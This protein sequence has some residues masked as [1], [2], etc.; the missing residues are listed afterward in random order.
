M[1]VVSHSQRRK[2]CP[3]GCRSS[4]RAPAT[5]AG[6]I[7]TAAMVMCVSSSVATM[8][9]H[10]TG[11]GHAIKE[12][13]KIHSAS[14]G[15]A[16]N[17]RGD[18][19]MASIVRGTPERRSIGP[20]PQEAFPARCPAADSGSA[21][22]QRRKNRR[23][24]AGAAASRS[25]VQRPSDGDLNAC[26]R[27]TSMRHLH[28]LRLIGDEALDHSLVL[29]GQQRAGGIDEPSARLDQP[30]AARAPSAARR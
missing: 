1:P 21:L 27:N 17:G 22:Q 26:G 12:F 20:P 8:S 14:S 11:S 30:A 13:Q 7:V 6:K 9:C 25:T 15:P 3:R 4:A 18:N 16:T 29:L 28:E 10:Q 2:K 24:H 23:S 5:D 19:A